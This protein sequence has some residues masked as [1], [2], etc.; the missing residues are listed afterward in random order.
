MKLGD[1]SNELNTKNKKGLG[2]WGEKKA[3]NYLINNNYAI[4]E[5]NFR[6]RWGEVDLIAIQ[7]E[8]LVFIEVKTRKSLSFG[9]PESSIN[10]RKKEKIR[11]LANYYL[12]KND[13]SDLQVRFD[14]IT[15]MISNDSNIK[16]SNSN[17]FDL[18]HI[19]NAF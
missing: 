13:Y 11:K 9:Q 16:R 8:F 2:S 1:K 10:Y 15:I 19:E 7:G 4:V 14:V 18:N 5:K 3:Q 12:L 17:N 6:N